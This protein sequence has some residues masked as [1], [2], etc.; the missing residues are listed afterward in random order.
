MAIPRARIP[1]W[2]VLICFHGFLQVSQSQYEQ[3]AQKLATAL[4]YDQQLHQQVSKPSNN[5]EGLEDGDDSSDTTSAASVNSDDDQSDVAS[6]AGSSD[7]SIDVA[8]I[9][10][11]EPQQQQPQQ[12]QVAAPKWVRVG[13][14]VC[15]STVVAAVLIPS[16]HDLT[17]AAKR[18][19]W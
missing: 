13:E 18:E 9:E 10:E 12:R 14:K 11:A 5:N 2:V 16:S 6:T 7:E 15:F 4:S 19:L 8:G 1:W 17:A 3:A